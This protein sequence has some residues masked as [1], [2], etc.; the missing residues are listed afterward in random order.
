MHLKF[1]STPGIEELLESLETAQDHG[2]SRGILS[3]INEDTSGDDSMSA[4]LQAF[5]DLPD[6]CKVWCKQPWFKTLLQCKVFVVQSGVN[7]R[8]LRRCCSVRREIIIGVVQA[9]LV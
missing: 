7:N 1:N 2:K 3:Q 8:G 5:Y 4:E 6:C 9:A